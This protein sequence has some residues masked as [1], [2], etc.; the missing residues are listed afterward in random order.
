[1]NAEQIFFLMNFFETKVRVRYAET[2][3]MGVVYH[4]NFA[5]YFEVAR[6]E[7]LRS[8]GVSYSDMERGGVMLPVVNLNINYRKP[9]HYDEVLTIKTRVTEKPTAKIIFEYEV[10]NEKNQ[11]ISDATSTLVF[12]NIATRKPMMCPEYLLSKI[13]M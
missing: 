10:Y 12:V 11:L 6:V 5:Q 4:G 7:W 2:D 3:Q 8:L 9:A 1:M 13:L